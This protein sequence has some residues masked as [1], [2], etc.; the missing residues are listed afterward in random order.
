MPEWRKLRFEPVD[1]S[2]QP[3]DI[4]VAKHRFRDSRR[5]LV[6]RIPQLG[7]QSKQVPLD[8]H[9]LG[10]DVGVGACRTRNA[11]PRAELVDLSACIDESVVLP[12][13]RALEERR[14]ARVAGPSVEFLRHKI[15]SAEAS[16]YGAD[17][18]K[19]PCDLLLRKS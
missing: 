10:V 1:R 12:N 8:P 7:T 19:W 2:L 13:P 5:D 17:Y 9:Q 4:R 14:L 3:F 11:Q 6:G 15:R 18:T 16:R